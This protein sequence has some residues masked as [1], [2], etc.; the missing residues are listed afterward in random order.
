MMRLNKEAAKAMQ[1]GRFHAATDVTGFGLLGHAWEMA[2]K[3]GVALEFRF[4]D[5]PFCPGALEYADLVL[6][7]GGANRNQDAY[8]QYVDFHPSLEYEERLL[9]FTPE[10]SGGLLISMPPDEIPLF[11]ARCE[12]LEQPA[13]VVG[14]VVEGTGVKV[15]A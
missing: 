3:S 14:Q 11:L 2:D 10:T 13:W 12:A 9:L 1:G 6:F 5:L 4:S 7:P 15:L 8:A